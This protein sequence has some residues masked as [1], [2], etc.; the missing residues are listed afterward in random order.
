VSAAPLQPLHVVVAMNHA[1]VIGANGGL[2]WHVPED[3]KHFK[4]LT[5]GHAMVMGR[6]TH[7]AIGRALPGRRNI[8]ITSRE[9]GTPG[10]EI[11]RSLDEALALARTT[12]PEPFVVGGG[13]I[14]ALALPLATRLH[15]TWIRE[16]VAGDTFFPAIDSSWREI[17][18]VAAAT[19]GVEFVTYAREGDREP[20]A[21]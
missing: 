12:D 17:E 6:K 14:Y 9:I 7:E 16:D 15:V 1:R 19:P 5:M 3:L 20:L 21:P 8:V 2:P 4:A 11:A 18:R 10:V 13:E